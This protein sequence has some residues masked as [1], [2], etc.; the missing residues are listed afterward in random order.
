MKY[1]DKTAAEY[2]AAGRGE[3]FGEDAR[4]GVQP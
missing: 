1:N 2:K 4:L 3:R